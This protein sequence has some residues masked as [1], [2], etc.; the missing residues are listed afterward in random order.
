MTFA[1]PWAFLLLAVLPVLGWRLARPGVP[2]SAYALYS[3][4]RL[5]PSRRYPLRAA[6]ARQ[7]PWLRLLALL[8]LI[9]LVSPEGVAVETDDTHELR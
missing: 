1:T 3:D 5:L 2:G 6:L 7:L 4:F 9:D 8:L